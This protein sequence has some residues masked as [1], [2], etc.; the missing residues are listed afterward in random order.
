MVLL[1]GNQS[2]SCN[3]IT[4]NWIDGEGLEVFYDQKKRS[5]PILL[6]EDQKKNRKYDQRFL[7]VFRRVLLFGKGVTYRVRHPNKSVINTKSSG[8]NDDDIKRLR[9][10]NKSIIISKSSSHDDYYHDDIINLVSTVASTITNY[11]SASGLFSYDDED[12]TRTTESLLDDD[13]EDDEGIPLKLLFNFEF[14]KDYDLLPS[15]EGN[16]FIRESVRKSFSID[17]F[18]EEGS[19][20]SASSDGEESSFFDLSLEGGRSF[21]ASEGGSSFSISEEK[22][23]FFTYSSSSEEEEEGIIFFLTCQRDA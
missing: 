6:E 5:S 16:S 4:G 21:R 12:E 3:I 7:R 18:S 9:H 1:L 11:S 20:F 15:S 23:S 13:E 19:F 22:E 14:L 17:T 8:H 10:P 2:S